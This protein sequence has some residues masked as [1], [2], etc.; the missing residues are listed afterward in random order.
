VDGKLNP[1]MQEKPM[2]CRTVQG[3]TGTTGNRPALNY[4]ATAK[5]LQALAHPLRLRILEVLQQGEMTC[6]ELQ[7]ALGCGQSMVSQQ[8]KLLEHQG[9]VTTRKAGTLKYCG[10]RNPDILKL[11][12][13]LSKHVREV[14]RK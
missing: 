5:V 9:L 4:D 11:F 8:V 13:C 14:L 10:I 3:K 6:G 12:S 7:N 1:I 2:R